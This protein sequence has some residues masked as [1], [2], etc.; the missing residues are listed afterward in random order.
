MTDA[1]GL[2]GQPLAGSQSDSRDQW[3]DDRVS[4]WLRV[5]LTLGVLLRLLRFALDHPLWRD[6]AFLVA[7]LVDRSFAGLTRP[8]DFGQVCPVLFL[9]GEK[10][11]VGLLGFHEWSLRVLPTVASIASLPLFCHLARRLLKGEAVVLA[12][13]ILAVGYTP[14][15]HGG[16]AKPYATDF[17]VALGL[18]TLAVEWVR[19]PSRAG[20]LWGLAALGP[21]AVGLSNPSVFVAA[22]LMLV[23]VVPVSKTRSGRVIVPFV[24]CCVGT[25]ATFLGLL[26]WINAP[27]GDHVMSWM[28]I[29]WAGS[30]PPRLVAPLLGWLVRVH[31]SQMFAYPAGGD[32]GASTLTFA[33]VVVA[34]VAYLRRGSKSVLALLLTPF[35]LGLIA[36]GL[37]R[38]PYGGSARTMQYVAP[39]IIL[40]AGLGAA[41]LLARLPRP[42]W[43]DRSF[44]LVASGLLVMG[45]GLGGWDWTHPYK[46]VEDQTARDFAHRVWAET[47]PGAE[48]LCA[49]GDLK[50]PLNPL[51]WEGER[52]A[53]YLCYRAIDRD[54]HHRPASPRLDRIS[55]AH[56]LRIVVFGSAPA[57]QV[58]VDAWV[59]Q[60]TRYRLRSKREEVLNAGLMQNKA[61]VE[62][63]YTIYEL[64]PDDR[65]MLISREN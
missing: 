21:L 40:L 41:V 15:R 9:W 53:F 17:L 24:V 31:T 47:S 32:R 14:I 3:A 52:A 10:A 30:F 12:V 65:T 42:S 59:H 16:E 61:P 11:V 51:V 2:V 63:R 22:S 60:N 18:I 35:A 49:R 26:R 5:F 13:A 37:G 28:R 23:L 29:Y 55:A 38:Y 45:L 25:G 19:S 36:A 43:R 39:A 50:L 46:A 8:L 58:T 64:V 48:V 54:R 27:Q 20:P 57:D 34:V 6:E 1:S 4:R 7:N 56:P 33:L 62:D 44:R